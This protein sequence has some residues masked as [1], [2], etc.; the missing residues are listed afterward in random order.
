MLTNKV[1]VMHGPIEGFN[2]EE[3]LWYLKREQ[4]LSSHGER[5]EDIFGINDDSFYHDDLKAL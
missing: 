5:F 3:K 1:V 2:A 4:K